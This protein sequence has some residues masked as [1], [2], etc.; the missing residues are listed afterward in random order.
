MS[1]IFSPE[2]EQIIAQRYLTEQTKLLAE[3]YGVSSSTIVN[4]A[5][6][7]G[8]TF[9]KKK[10]AIDLNKETFQNLMDQGNSFSDIAKMY[11]VSKTTISRIAKK[12]NIP[13]KPKKLTQ[14]EKQYIGTQYHNLNISVK[15]LAEQFDVSWQYITA[16]ME[17]YGENIGKRRGNRRY[18]KD[19][20][21]FNTIDSEEKAYWLG[22]L[23]AD[24]CIYKSKRKKCSPC[25]T[26][27]LHRQDSKHLE[28]FLNCIN[29]NLPISYFSQ[30]ASIQIYSTKM[31]EDLEK[32]GCTERKTYILTMPDIPEKY[33][34]HFIRGYFDGDG[35]ISHNINPKRLSKV[36]I[37]LVGF[38]NFLVGIEKVLQKNNL[39]YIKHKISSNKVTN[40]VDINNYFCSINFYSKQ[41][42]QKFLDFLYK[43]SHIYLDRKYQ[44]YQQY[45]TYF[46]ENPN[47]RKKK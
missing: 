12:Y 28:K 36:R 1:R 24:G 19:D 44:L 30:C 38:N 6:R 18:K 13:I 34:R 27:S 33:I 9:S 15:E 37:S 10:D 21:Y 26:I 16:I 43:N 25:V 20:N 32:L 31:V 17:K 4:I 39:F 7:N 47:I 8:I 14:E 5:R 3:E 46:S 22:F 41:D 29:S 23:Y 35:S 2:Q 42:K 40:K 45:T 11:H